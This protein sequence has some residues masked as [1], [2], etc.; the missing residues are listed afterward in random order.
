MGVMSHDAAGERTEPHPLSRTWVPVALVALVVVSFISVQ[1]FYYTRHDPILRR[2]LVRVP[3]PGWV[4][5]AEWTALAAAALLIAWSA[6]RRKRDLVVLFVVTTFGGWVGWACA[7]GIVR[8]RV[9]ETLVV[10]E[11]RTYARLSRIQMPP[12][13]DYIGVVESSGWLATEYAIVG[14]GLSFPPHALIV[15]PRGD[16]RTLRT[17]DSGT[18]VVTYD[19]YL[20]AAADWSTSPDSGGPEAPNVHVRAFE[21]IGP[22][23]E[24]E[25]RHVARILDVIGKAKTHGDATPYGEIGVSALPRDAELVAA[26]RHANSWVRETA[27]QFILAGGAALYPEATRALR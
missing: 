6:W 19:G 22:T 15:A 8:W 17:L 14:S 25:P 2:L 20:T 11:G 1:N 10:P 21:F 26:L 12:A 3:H 4:R 16:E 9:H 24:G 27:R 13:A 7:A 18:V 5:A 23:G